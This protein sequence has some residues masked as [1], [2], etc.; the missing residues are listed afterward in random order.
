[1]KNWTRRKPIAPPGERSAGALPPSLSWPQLMAMGVGAII[2]TG[3]LTLIG[4]GV[5]RAGPAVLL[6]FAIAG[7]VCACAALAYA[8]LSAMMPAAGSAYSYSYAGLGEAF[9]WIVGWSLILEYSLVVSTVA[10][11]WSGYASPLLMGIGFPEVLTRG[12]ELGGLINLPAVA[13]IAVVA[14]LLLLGTR[15]SAR[16]NSVLVVVKIVTLLLFVGYTLPYFDAAHLDPF[17]PYGYAAQVDSDGVQ[18]GVMAAAAIIFFAFYGFDAISTAAEETKRPARDL[19]IAIIGS[20]AVCTLI[21]MLVAATAVGATP[22]TTFADSPEPLALILRSIGQGG[23]AQIV[24]TTAVV[25]L[26]T[27]LLAFLYGQSRIFL[28]MARDGFLPQR[29]AHISG[30]GTPARITLLTAAIV[31]V[32]AGLL[33][34]GKVAA[35][36]NAGTLI[37][38]IAVGV[39]LLVLRRRAPDAPRPFR[40]RAAWLVGLGTIGGCL[41]LFLSLPAETLLWCLV[42]NLIGLALYAAYGQHRSTL[43]KAARGG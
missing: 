36:A 40:V 13:I 38:F 28:A 10:V 8:E 26:P 31:A 6:S 12:P 11:G 39:C 43:G 15:E 41:Y 42:W 37:A 20:M 17:M 33:P 32:L 9:A 29:L 14:G 22:F 34:I 35:L 27:V 4:V 25:A 7:A 16:I 3:I 24:A 19:P 5:D 18:R 21:Y 2:G 30:R 1:M 23:I